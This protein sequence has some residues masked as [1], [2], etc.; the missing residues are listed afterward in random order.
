MARFGIPFQIHTH[1]YVANQGGIWG[2]SGACLLLQRARLHGRWQY[3]FVESLITDAN[4]LEQ[5]YRYKMMYS[6]D[7]RNQDPEKAFSLSQ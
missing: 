7:Y 6:P 4:V 3:L 5:N 1:K 2:I